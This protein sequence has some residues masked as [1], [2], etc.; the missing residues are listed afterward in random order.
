M[1]QFT[2]QLCPSAFFA[3]TGRQKIGQGFLNYAV[4][5]VIRK[6]E[7][8]GFALDIFLKKVEKLK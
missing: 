6:Q 4:Y 5:E 2:N 7:R 1:R 8:F 3:I